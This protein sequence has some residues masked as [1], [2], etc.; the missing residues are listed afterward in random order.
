MMLTAGSV[1]EQVQSSTF[2][3]E[4]DRVSVPTIVQIGTESQTVS[5]IISNNDQTPTV[6]SQVEL[7][8][9]R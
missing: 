8:E 9:I 1:V 7:F 6:L 2:Y 5:N 3:A 4:D